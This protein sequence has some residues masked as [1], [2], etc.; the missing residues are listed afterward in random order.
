MKLLACVSFAVFLAGDAVAQEVAP[1][2]APK[3]P[4]APAPPADELAATLEQAQALLDD[5]DFE[6]ARALL[7]AARARLGPAAPPARLLELLADAL[8]RSGE[9]AAAGEV[10]SAAREQRPNSRRALIGLSRLALA[11]GDGEEALALSDAAIAASPREPEPWLLRCAALMHANRTREA[12]AA[13]QRADALLAQARAAG[14]A[15]PR[16]LR[17]ALDVVRIAG[18]GEVTVR[19]REYITRLEYDLR[20]GVPVVAA[21]LRGADEREVTVPMVIDTGGSYCMTLDDSVG[22]ALGLDLSPGGPIEGVERGTI[23]SS[24]ATVPF[25]D[26]AG[27]TVRDAPALLYPVPSEPALRLR[28]EP[29]YRGVLGTA[30]LQRRVLVF[31]PKSQLIRLMTG[32]FGQAALAEEERRRA[33]AVP[34]FVIAD[35]KI[36]L[37]A[38]VEGES[39]LALLDTGAAATALSA[40]LDRRTRRSKEQAAAPASPAT[41]DAPPVP[42]TAS[43]NGCVVPIAASRDEAAVRSTLDERVSPRLGVEISLLLGM[44][45][46]G[47]CDRLV[48]DYVHQQLL[49]VP[50]PGR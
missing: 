13:R 26:L 31:L 1:P 40:R 42:F 49:I 11:R 28:P 10:Y 48:V 45:F 22:A 35:G 39:V 23:E 4:V 33:T 50:E 3:A 21:T 44:D 14:R 24:Y 8:W 41:P 34:F 43:L 38:E 18:L 6:K 37:R 36:A 29:P 15:E 5:D 2:P 30:M 25:L 19:R 47:R 46:V 17:A 16:R 32:R 7:D 12:I 9:L 20:A 27:W